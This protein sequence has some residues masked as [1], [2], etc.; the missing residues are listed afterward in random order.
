L[1]AGR[2]GQRR[3]TVALALSSAGVTAIVV[4]AA[5]G[6]VGAVRGRGD[7]PSTN[8]PS[9][10]ASV[11]APSVAPSGTASCTIQLLPTPPGVSADMRVAAPTGRIQAGQTAVGDN[12]NKPVLWTNG[13]P[14]LL[15]APTAIL[16][17]SYGVSGVNSRGDLALVTGTTTPTAY[18]FHDG[19]FT[20]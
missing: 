7:A 5:F 20:K 14:A 4:V 8:P 19:K 1:A 13:V 16:D 15:N 3:R 10:H 6:A 17:T 9:N 11:T 18:R 2:R 12:Q